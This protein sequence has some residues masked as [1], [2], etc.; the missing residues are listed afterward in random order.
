VFKITQPEIFYVLMFRATCF[1]L[2]LGHRHVVLRLH[3]EKFQ[4]EIC[5]LHVDKEIL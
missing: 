4:V 2:F 3:I 5:P 1:S